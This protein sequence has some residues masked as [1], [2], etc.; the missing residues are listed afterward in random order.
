MSFN[1]VLDPVKFLE[2]E[3]LCLPS[4]I[5]CFILLS[6]FLIS[7]KISCFIVSSSLLL[8]ALFSVGVSVPFNESARLKT[9]KQKIIKYHDQSQDSFL[10][11]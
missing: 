7:V 3:T 11:Q 6:S 8:I 5:S 10:L 9:T 2:Q 4:K 1:P